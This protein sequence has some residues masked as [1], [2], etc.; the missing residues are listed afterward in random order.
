VVNENLQPPLR[1]DPAASPAG[2]GWG[3]KQFDF[4]F[5]VF[6]HTRMKSSS[7]VAYAIP[8]VDFMGAG[9]SQSQPR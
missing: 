6:N 5:F 3:N 2:S 4:F 8:L 1:L 9:S 7:S